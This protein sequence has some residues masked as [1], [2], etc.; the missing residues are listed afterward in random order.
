[1]YEIMLSESQERMLA[2]C[3]KG[4]EE[5]VAAI[6]RKWGLNAVVIGHVTDDGFVRVKEGHRI[7]AEIPAKALTDECPTYHLEA[8]TPDYIR[9][10]QAFDPLS[11]PEPQSPTLLKVIND[12]MPTYGECLHR[13]LA[14]PSIA[15]K[16]WV[17]QQY[18]S[19]V[20]T[21]TVIG[22]GSGDA[23]V[24]RIRNTGKGIALKT[25][26][27]G[28]YCALDP[29]VGAQIAVAEAA[30]NVVCVGARPAAIT[31]C[32]NFA[33]P[34]KPA[35]F[36]QFRRAV[37][38]IAAATEALGIPVVSGNVSFYNETPETAIYP[39][40]VIGMLGILEDVHRRCASAVRDEGDTLVL[41]RADND[42]TGGLGGSEYLAVIH[43]REAGKPPA[44]DLAAEKR[45][46]DCLLAAIG[47]GLLASAHDCSDGG[48]A[49]CLAEKVIPTGIGA[50][51]LLRYV[52]FGDL[53]PSAILFGEA[54]S[55]VVVTVRTDKQLKKLEQL[56]AK[57]GI[58]AL[59]MGTV[60]GENLRIAFD[61]ED[62]LDEPVADLA[63]SYTESIQK[64]MET[65][66]SRGEKS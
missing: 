62:L 64:V 42:P 57:H 13:L 45:L 9:R 53:P 10:V 40:P 27:N 48:L 41:L 55:R 31:D 8:T 15:S 61:G 24:L 46:H 17:T 28:R 58:R 16:E 47:E 50:A 12:G 34:E 38:G 6:F 63:R 56:A 1:P 3:R 14:S 11:L 60:G 43:N 44:I 52:D 5:R 19:M 37:E 4:T 59:W 33:N 32:L 18:D 30:R 65:A 20:Q 22:P 25:D 36:W 7:A 39:T 23:A 26:G 21:Q 35:I 66:L 49:V 51:I 2:I 54:Q 29:Y